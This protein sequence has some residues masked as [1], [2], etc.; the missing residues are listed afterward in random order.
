MSG[1]KKGNIADPDLRSSELPAKDG[2]ELKNRINEAEKYSEL[3]EKIDVDSDY[4]DILATYEE[5]L[6]RRTKA[7]MKKAGGAADED[8]E[9]A[10]ENVMIAADEIEPDTDAAAQPEVQE[11]AEEKPADKKEKARRGDAGAALYSYI[12]ALGLAAGTGFKKLLAKPKKL[13]RSIVGFL[14][15]FFRFIWLGFKKF[16][17]LISHTFVEQVRDFRRDVH[18]AMHYLRQSRHEP[19]TL[20]PILGHY[21]KKAFT[22]HT[23]MF[24]TIAN[25]AL[26]VA[27]VLA[28]VL[29]VNYWSSVT[30]ALK[31][32]YDSKE[33]GYI[34]D[35]SV[36]NEAQ[37][38]A[39]AR[40]TTTKTDSSANLEDP[41]YELSLVNINELVDSSILCDRIIENSESNVTNACGI[42]IDDEFVCSVKNETDATSVF[43]AILEKNQVADSNSFVDFV[44]KVEYVQGLYPDDPKT[45]WDASKL[46][47][48]LEQTKQAKKTYTVK[49]G[50]TVYGIAV[51]NGLTEKQLMEL[52]P[53]MGEYIHSGDQL[54]VSNEVNYIR[55]KVMKTET[56]T[57]EV[58]YE[59]EKTNDASMFKGT[60]RVTRKGEKGE[61]TITELV[62]YIDGQRVTSQEVSRVRTKEPV[63]EKVLVGTKSTRVSSS[64]S[65]SYSVKVSGR[66]FVWPAPACT[67]V[68]SPYGWRTLRGYSDFHTGVDLTLPGGGSTGAVIVAS[69]DGTV[70]S[71]RRSNSGYGHC[72]V[73]NHGGG[74]KTRYAH[75]LAGSISVSVGQTVSAGQAI[76]RVGSTGNVTGP[77]LH[78]EIIINGSTVNPLPYIR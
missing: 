15:Y 11:T 77:H 67:F 36:Y 21:V 59:T 16:I 57:V 52:N 29:T 75:C 68:S 18:S 31:V 27:A 65:G 43:N 24:R 13:G 14:K 32:S 3:F 76:A 45:M 60:T 1:K 12:A 62:T 48:Q 23:Q 73:I 10:G 69:L 30:F 9:P 38:A 37:S 2:N 47:K 34:S 22:T 41:T 70:E 8:D 56:R 50:D 20:F 53:D 72:V 35:E 55:V 46:K 74:V 54:T 71:V 44:E 42:Y 4:D 33:L 49:D 5:T 17:H 7:A 25:F 63:N 39:K 40:M 66:G 78:F 19:K 51:A 58:D 64:S 26:P 6:D 28:F 61:E